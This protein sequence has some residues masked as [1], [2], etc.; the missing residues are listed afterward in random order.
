MRGRATRG[1]RQ[2]TE[3]RANRRDRASGRR[4]PRRDDATR[5]ASPSARCQSPQRAAT[6]ADGA[7]VVMTHRRADRVCDRA[8]LDDRRTASIDQR[9]AMQHS[10]RPPLDATRH[11][12]GR[13]GRRTMQRLAHARR[14]H[15]AVATA[16]TGRCQRR[17]RHRR[18]RARPQPANACPIDDQP[19][20][21]RSGDIV[22]LTSQ[23]D[24]FT[25]FSCR[26]DRRAFVIEVRRRIPRRARVGRAR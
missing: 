4:R 19:A 2:P 20:Q 15:R 24:R 14:G 5:W 9:L 3:R 23:E 26:H 1:G 16:R 7:A 11:A 8:T 25:R 10:G 17:L 22:R 12:T 6:F 13:D 21:G 18:C